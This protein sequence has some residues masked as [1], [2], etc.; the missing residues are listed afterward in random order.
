[1]HT[2]IHA[3]IHTCAYTHSVGQSV[4]H[5]IVKC[6]VG[7]SVSHFMGTVTGFNLGV[8]GFNVGVTGFNLGVT[9]NY[10]EEACFTYATGLS[11]IGIYGLDRFVI[12]FLIVF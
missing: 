4:I 2:Y 8:T 10:A 1:M 6:P 9:G 5:F 3:C 7:Q 12:H 11:G